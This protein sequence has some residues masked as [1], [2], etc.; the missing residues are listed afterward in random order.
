MEITFVPIKAAGQQFIVKR[1]ETETLV[2]QTRTLM[3]QYQGFLFGI[4][5]KKLYAEWDT[6]QPDLEKAIATLKKAGDFLN[7]MYDLFT[8]SDLSS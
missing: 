7:Q 5:T 1:G 3:S 8:Q 4:R 2:F 6:M